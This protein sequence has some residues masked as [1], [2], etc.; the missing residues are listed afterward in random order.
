MIW[1]ILVLVVLLIIGVAVFL[2]QPSFGKLPEGERLERIKKSPNYK[3]GKF[4]NLSPTKMM[5]SDKSM[6]RTFWEFLFVKVK[7]LRP[8]KNLPAI[9]TDLKKFAPD[10]EILVWLGHSS[11]YMQIEGKRFLVDPVL[12]SASPV[13]FVNKAFKGTAIY[14]PDDIPDIDYL[15]ITHDHWDHLDYNVMRNLKNRTGKVICPLGVGAHLEYWGFNPATITELDW[16]E[17]SQLDNNIKITALPA[18]HFSGRG[19]VSN[20]TLWAGYMLQS[21][22]G[23]IYL[24]GDSGYDTHFA[25][26]KRKFGTI[27]FAMMENGQYNEDWRYIHMLPEDLVKAVKELQPKRLMTVHNSKYAL[28]R[29]PWYEPL[30]KIAVASEGN[31][32]NLITPKIGEPVRLRDSLQT[33]SKWWEEG[34]VE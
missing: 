30:Q 6:L 7:D 26:I 12:V 13:S 4:Q 29:H 2:Q 17:D 9:K 14:Q 32:F 11:L 5:A 20:H 15:I 24:S 31:A 19:L 1:T 8:S 28:G 23:N 27:D 3:D 21:S 34:N 22:L 33:F 25:E 18:R 10:E 16:N